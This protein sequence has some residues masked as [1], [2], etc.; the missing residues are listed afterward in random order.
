MKHVTIQIF[1]KVQGVFF[2]ESVKNL[3][4]NL[5]LVGF[6]ENCSDGS[7]CLHAQ[8]NEK[9]LEELILWCRS[10]P[11]LA[12]VRELETKENS[13]TEFIDFVIYE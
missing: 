11:P 6:V 9:E 5:G 2:R 3:A 8:G 4:T 7:V 13:L 10:G 12:S 1:G